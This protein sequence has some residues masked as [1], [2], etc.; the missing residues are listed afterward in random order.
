MD[1]LYIFD[2]T[3]SDKLS[4]FRGGGRIIQ[5]LKENLEDAIFIT[6]LD[7]FSNEQ[8]L[9]DRAKAVTTN[10][11]IP[12]W[13][14]LE[15]P[16][17][18]KRIA[19]KQYLI[20][21][22]VIP[23]KYPSHFPA[24]LRGKFN[25]LRNLRNLKLYDKII[26]ISQAS[27]MDIIKYLKVPESKVEVIYPTLSEIFLKHETWNMKHKKNKMLQASGFMLHEKR[28]AL[29]VGDVNYNKNLVNLARAIKLADVP[30]LFVGKEF[31]VARGAWHVA[32]SDHIEQNEFQE[33]LK[34]AN[35]D[36][37][38]IFAGYLPDS[39]LIQ[40]YKRAVCNILVSRDEGFGF[41]Y[42]EAASQNCP[43][44]LS[45][46]PVF[47]EIAKKT[48]FFADP[49]NP[50]DIANK[51]KKIFSDKKIR[52]QLGQSAFENSQKY[53][54]TNFKKELNSLLTK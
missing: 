42:L 35:E 3:N 33:F 4:Q 8:L 50:E 26:T 11:I 19:H 20:I 13:K 2:P 46:I 54:P 39:D 14:P 5:I 9:R 45:N 25:L 22:D 16:I 30:C 21:Y 52:V 28:F 27:K 18:N 23:L 48:A 31:D 47:H 10:L 40:L 53:F 43:S 17:L 36:S 1:K 15:P 44:I 51:I 24:G 37:R 29:Y 49:E 6:S 7:N 38:F 34:L 32:R 12:F 41:S